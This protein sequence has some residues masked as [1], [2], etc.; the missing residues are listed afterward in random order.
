[1]RAGEGVMPLSEADLE[2]IDE[3]ARLAR[4]HEKLSE[5]VES[6]YVPVNADMPGP[7]NFQRAF[8]LL[9]QLG[10]GEASHEETE[11]ALKGNWPEAWR[12]NENGERFG[13]EW[14]A[15]IAAHARREHKKRR[16]G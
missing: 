6:K 10:L 7:L 13:D 5:L 4:K 1:M 9:A 12:A 2:C 11:T 14:F 16:Q 15:V 8:Y 3:M